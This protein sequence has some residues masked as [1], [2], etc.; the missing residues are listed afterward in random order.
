M[1]TPR[2]LVLLQGAR[3]LGDLVGL[4]S[5]HGLDAA[6]ADICSSPASCSGSGYAA[7]LLACAHADAGALGG[8][9]KLLAPGAKA[10]L[11]LPRAEQGD[12]VSAMILA[13]FTDCQASTSPAGTTVTAKLPAF[14]VGS[15][16]AIK[17]KPK[18]AAAAAPAA[19][20]LSADDGDEELVD[21]EELLTED[22]RRRPVPGVAAD[23][24]E[25]G[26]GGARKACKNCSCGRAEAEAAGQKVTLTQ[27][28]LDNPQSSCG[29]CSLG[30]AFRCAGCP[31]RGLP[32]FEAGKKI[33]LPADFL[34]A[35]APRARRCV[36]AA[37]VEP[38]AAAAGG[39]GE[40]GGSGGSSGD[41]RFSEPQL[42]ALWDS[43]S[44]ALLKL[45]RTGVTETHARSL[46]E[47]LT[48]HKL[49]KV[50]LNGARDEPAAVADAAAALAAASG[51]ALLRVKG[52]TMLFADAASSDEHLLAVAEAAAA[53]TA[54]W[55]LK[56]A[57]AASQRAAA[58]EAA[59]AKRTANASRSRRR[60]GRLISGVAAPS[61]GPLDRK[62]LAAEAEELAGRI[63]A[64]E[65]AAEA[66]GASGARSGSRKPLWRK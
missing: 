6:S 28:M 55:K 36:A 22:D 12:A 43:V 59:D 24:C 37:A 9:A 16:D 10:V 48:A 39:G 21:D 63:V 45:G 61:K 29:N 14:A 64:E 2:A 34:T 40:P 38:A 49:V 13:G 19:W 3:P 66:G 53:G 50:Q 33:E 58:R 17:L 4:L 23:D 47:L 62:A 60:V 56:R 51:A 15:K 35:D 46:G 42:A 1:A 65:A 18:A 11:C 5:E 26:A 30:D 32:A 44:R 7:A 25:V 41:A 20:V 52:S 31:Y 54:A 57:E 8:V 27:E